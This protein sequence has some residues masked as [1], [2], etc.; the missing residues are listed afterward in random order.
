[1]G[2]VYQNTRLRKTGWRG[3]VEKITV[4]ELSHLG[5]EMAL[6]KKSALID[7]N[8]TPSPQKA[9]KGTTGLEPF[10]K[11]TLNVARRSPLVLVQRWRYQQPERH[12]FLRQGQSLWYILVLM[13]NQDT[14]CPVGYTW[15]SMKI[16]EVVCSWLDKCC[17]PLCFRERGTDPM[18]DQVAH[19]LRLF[20]VPQNHRVNFF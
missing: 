20:F 11:T 12:R 18:Y 10:D 15:P 16:A 5:P 1:M 13:T 7:G 17:R 3:V 2:D 19:L 14:S 8:S 6:P 9:E 4:I